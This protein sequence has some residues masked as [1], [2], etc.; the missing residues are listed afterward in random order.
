VLPPEARDEVLK[1]IFD[2][3]AGLNFNICR[4][5]IGA[6]DYATDWYSL[7]EAPDDFELKH[8]SLARDKTAL[9]PYVKA[10]MRFQPHLE[11]WGSPWSP[12]T[13]MKMNHYYGAKDS[14]GPNHF[15]QQD[16]YLDAYARYLSKYVTS[17]RA[18][19]VPIFAVAVQNEPFF[20]PGYPSCRWTPDEIRNFISKYLGPT[21]DRE[22]T[23]AKIWLGT[24]N[25]NDIRNY[26]PILSDADA[27]HFVD[28]V[29]VQ[30]A[31]KNALPDLVKQYP[32]LTKVETESECGNGSF[33][34]NAAEYTFSL[35]KYYL[36]HGVT[37]YEYWNLILDETG[38]ST[39]G[40]KQNAL[41]TIHHTT[42][43]VT[44]TPE[45]YLFKHFS[46]FVQAGA[47]KLKSDGN[48]DDAVAFRGPDGNLT[49]VAMN[50]RP[51]EKSLTIK[52]GS[53]NL[54]VSLP[55]RSF[56]TFRVP[57]VECEGP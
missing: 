51:E 7:D 47:V 56:N 23:G 42:A 10:A 3:Q 19:G 28:A 52:L 32:R 40:W 31:G 25:N 24:F 36:N 16:K 15:I 57:V 6:N 48:F 50:A 43:K 8:F 39:W 5:P 20:S 46:H 1:N 53:R 41:V 13:W 27:A 34:W 33:D 4:M 37:I 29:G 14:A 55:P 44:Y 18:E 26:E 2:P 22:K 45:F 9:I 11:V 38:K 49:I 12:P 17:Y 54:T 35:I 21:F 30:W